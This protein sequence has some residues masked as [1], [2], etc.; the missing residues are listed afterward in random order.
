M[1]ATVS[2]DHDNAPETICSLKFAHRVRTVELGNSA[3][4]NGHANLDYTSNGGS[5]SRN[6]NRTHSPT[7]MKSGLGRKTPRH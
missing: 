4:G 7:I 6:V 5:P 3:D 1:I 2:P